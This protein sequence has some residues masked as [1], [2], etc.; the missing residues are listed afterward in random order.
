MSTQ[1]LNQLLRELKREL[2]KLYGDQLVAL[3]LYGSYAR[4]EA[5]EDSDIDVAMILKNY[6]R[7]ALEINRTSAVASQLSLDYDSLIALVPL[8]EHEWREKKSF[9]MNNLRA[10]G[11]EIV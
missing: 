1:Q 4:G 11:I 7:P 8:R 2:Q 10:E 9:F 6:E 5:H 3:I